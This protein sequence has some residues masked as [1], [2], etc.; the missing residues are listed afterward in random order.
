MIKFIKRPY[1]VKVSYIPH[2]WVISIEDTSLGVLRE[3]LPRLSWPNE[4]NERF[5][6]EASF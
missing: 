2:E 3:Y 6:I 4:R 5:P 1:G